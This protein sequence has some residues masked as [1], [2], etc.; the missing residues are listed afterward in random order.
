MLGEILNE[1]LY[2]KIAEFLQ[3]RE[4]FT[5]ATIF[6]KTGSVPRTAGAK[7][8]VRADDSIIGTIGGG[9]LEAD[10][11]HLARKMLSSK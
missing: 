6:D 3:K 1:R 7:M 8:M 11:M 5:V 4:S 9:R 10:T 2:R